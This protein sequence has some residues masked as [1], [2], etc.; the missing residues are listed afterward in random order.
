MC[1]RDSICYNATIE[2][3]S[4]E[5]DPICAT[6]FVTYPN[7]CHFRK[8]QCKSEEEIE[9]LFKDE[10]KRCLN[11]PCPIVDPSNASLDD[12]IFLCDQ[13]GETKSKCEFEMLRCIYEVKFGY[14]ITEAYVSPFT[15]EKISIY[16][17]TSGWALLSSK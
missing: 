3:C 1:T 14:N 17:N 11:T 7:M 10:C 15:L 13:N 8:A 2:V 16:S 4:S 9:I 5:I 12:S 6:D